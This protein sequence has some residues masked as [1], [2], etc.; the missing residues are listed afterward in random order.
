MALPVREFERAIEAFYY[1]WRDAGAACTPPTRACE[2]YHSNERKSSWE[3]VRVCQSYS[4]KYLRIARKLPEGD[5]DGGT[6]RSKEYELLPPPETNEPIPSH[7]EGEDEDDNDPEALRPP[8]LPPVIPQPA[9]LYDILHSPIYLVPVLYLTFTSLS[10][11]KSL[12][13]PS[14]SEIYSLLVP[15]A[16]KTPMRNVG[17]MG[18][19]SMAEHPVTGMPAFFV[20]PCRTQEVLGELAGESE[21]EGCS[22]VGGDHRAALEYLLLWFGVIGASVGLNVPVDVAMRLGGT[23]G[24]LGRC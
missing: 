4:A 23:G 8:V 17:V 19:L 10:T 15:S 12:P 20:H 3:D 6:S 2:D 13:L 18:A 11:K 14:A 7:E 24:E 21:G 22:G 9:I 16:L 5:G 1:A